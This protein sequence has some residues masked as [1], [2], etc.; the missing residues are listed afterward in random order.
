M[1]TIAAAVVTAASKDGTPESP[2]FISFLVFVS[3]R[4]KAI[5]IYKCVYFLV[6]SASTS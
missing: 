2:L 6:F 5:T 4:G 3:S 1:D